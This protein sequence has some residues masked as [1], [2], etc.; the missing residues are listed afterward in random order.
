MCVGG[1]Q[2]NDVDRSLFA[3]L[4]TLLHSQSFSILTPTRFLDWIANR[5]RHFIPTTPQAF[6]SPHQTQKNSSCL[7]RLVTINYCTMMRESHTEIVTGIPYSGNSERDLEQPLLALEQPSIDE[8]E[9]FKIRGCWITNTLTSF[10]FISGFWLGFLIQSVSLGSTAILAIRWGQQ[11]SAWISKQDEFYHVLFFLFS[12]SWWLLFPV[13]CFALDGGLTGNG[14][15]LFERCFFS[16]RKTSVRDVFLGG[17][18][19][20]VGIVVGCFFVW[21]LVDLYFG[22]SATVFVTLLFS[23]LS[24]LSLCYGMVL[25]HDRYIMEDE[26]ES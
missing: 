22:A 5:P 16:K 3:T 25:I 10:T 24:C 1:D 23:F 11:S 15:S 4:L 20:H 19:F 6:D 9:E 8:N 13:I 12:Q 17:V 7:T 14:N 18:R 21:C 26:D 2:P